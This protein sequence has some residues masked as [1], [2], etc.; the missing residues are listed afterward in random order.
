MKLTIEI[1]SHSE[2]KKKIE[3][4]NSVMNYN[5]KNNGLPKDISIHAIVEKGKHKQVRKYNELLEYIEYQPIPVSIL[6]TTNNRQLNFYTLQ[7]DGT[8]FPLIPSTTHDGEPILQRYTT[9][10]NY[11]KWNIADTHDLFIINRCVF[12]NLSV[13]PLQLFSI[14]FNVIEAIG[15][16]RFEPRNIG[17][18]YQYLKF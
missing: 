17:E 18:P 4:F 10:W 11:K 12:I 5:K 8:G 13:E 7:L 15:V 1:Q 14:E 6:K 2:K 3:L 16:N 9:K